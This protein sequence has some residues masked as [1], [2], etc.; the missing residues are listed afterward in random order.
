MRC[1]GER[2]ALR[3]WARWRPSPLA[4]GR[5]LP[6]PRLRRAYSTHPA[7]RTR[8]CVRLS[9]PR[10]ELRFGDGAPTGFSV[11]DGPT[12]HERSCDPDSA[13]LDLHEI[14]P[15]A[16]GPLVFQRPA[17]SG[18]AAGNAKY[19]ELAVSDIAG[20]LPAVAPAGDGRGAPC[21]LANETP[22]QVSVRSIPRV[23]H[24]KRPQDL[25]TGSNHGASFMHYGDPAADQGT[26][27]SIQYT[28]LLWSFTDVRGGGMVRTLLAPN[29]V[30]RVCAV[31]PITMSSWDYAGA[32]NGRVTARYVRVVAGTCPLYGWMVWSHTHLDRHARPVAHAVPL[33]TSAARSA[34]RI[35]A[36]PFSAPAA[37]P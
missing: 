2:R 26:T 11:G 29:Q 8:L 9:S 6:E 36:C 21:L 18:R 22:Y 15:S 20:P 12:A 17:Y 31:E 37:T 7:R 32:V 33:G 1:S 4:R 23:M 5:P 28:Y 13:L 24:Y 10:P 16:A 3:S 25:R 14:L 30:V 34:A 27:H 19:G 35:R